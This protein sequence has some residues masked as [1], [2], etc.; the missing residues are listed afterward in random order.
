MNLLCSLLTMFLFPGSLALPGNSLFLGDDIILQDESL[1][2]EDDS[3]LLE[4]DIN[5]LQSGTEQANSIDDVSI[6]LQKSSVNFKF[7]AGIGVIVVL[8]IIAFIVFKKKLREWYEHRSK[9]L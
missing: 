7:V 3:F 4:E 1:D 8:L 5:E 2:S 6:N 9:K